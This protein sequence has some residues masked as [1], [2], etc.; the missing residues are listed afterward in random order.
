MRSYLDVQK[1]QKLDI[2]KQLSFHDNL[3]VFEWVR[4]N[5]P[6]MCSSVRTLLKQSSGHL[7]MM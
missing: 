5:M 3:M 7:K 2:L 6:K 1:E 4:S